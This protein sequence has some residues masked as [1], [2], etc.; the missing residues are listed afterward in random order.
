MTLT[1]T[2]KTTTKKHYN[3]NS[4][5]L[6]DCLPTVVARNGQAL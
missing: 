1:T 6:L 3:N 4:I 5:N 2:K